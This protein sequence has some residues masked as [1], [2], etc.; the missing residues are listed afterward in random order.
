MHALHMQQSI[1]SS[2]QTLLMRLF[3]CDSQGNSKNMHAGVST[4]MQRLMHDT[5]DDML[6]L[7]P[8]TT[9]DNHEKL[10]AD[11][12]AGGWQDMHVRHAQNK[13]R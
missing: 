10:K 7:H 8:K 4:C 12:A 6:M 9:A 2:A 1:Q 5:A 3:C 11:K 13:E